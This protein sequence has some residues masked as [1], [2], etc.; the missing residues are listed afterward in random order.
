MSDD[1][2]D[3]AK[4]RRAREVI[5]GAGW[6]FDQYVNQNMAIVLASSPG[7]R[8][9]R[10]DAYLRAHIAAAMKIEM[11]SLIE[12][13]AATARLADEKRKQQEKRDGR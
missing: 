4:L 13:A 2:S 8:D 10:E 7:E 11:E 5:T 9:K 3:E 6:L 12:D 1:L